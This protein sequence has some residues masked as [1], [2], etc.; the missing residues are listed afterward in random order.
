MNTFKE[1]ISDKKRGLSLQVEEPLAELAG[2]CVQKWHEIDQLDALLQKHLT[3]MPTC[4]RIYV[5]DRH[6][7]QHSSTVM[8]ASV[9]CTARQ[10]DLS[11]EANLAGTLPFKGMCLTDAYLSRED[12]A[13]CITAIHAISNADELLGFVLAD[14]SMHALQLDTNRS[15]VPRAWRQFKGDPAI[16]GMVFQQQRVF[17]LMDEYIDEACNVISALVRRHGIFH[18]K[19][20]F[21]SSRATFWC[22]NDPYNYR[23]HGVEEFMNANV[24]LAYAATPYP[25][26]AQVSEAEI[27]VVLR[28]FKVLRL[29]DDNLYLRSASLNIMNNMIGLT[30]S[31]DG[32]HYMPVSEFLQKDISF[33]LGTASLVSSDRAAS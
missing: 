4:G 13:P 24:C 14:F 15:C 23:L 6:N 9:D 28:Y 7:H 12:M 20:H 2:Q 21:S 27:D 11:R 26:T 30:F 5:V 22:L 17:S 10:R 1:I 8:P 29:A 32:T 16:R 18:I 3:A 19:L 25:A 31:C 33:W